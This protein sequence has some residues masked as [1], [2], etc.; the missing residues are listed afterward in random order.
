MTATLRVLRKTSTHKSIILIGIALA[1]AGSKQ[2][3]VEW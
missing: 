1:A 2:T 3:G